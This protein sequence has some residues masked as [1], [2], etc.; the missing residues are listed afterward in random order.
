MIKRITLSIP[1]DLLK[2]SKDYAKKHHISLNQLI[3]DLLS[4]TVAWKPN[5]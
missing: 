4:K 5:R 3:C 2:M 1:E